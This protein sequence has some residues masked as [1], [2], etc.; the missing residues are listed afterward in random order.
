MDHTREGLP[1]YEHVVQLPDT[2]VSGI[3]GYSGKCEMMETSQTVGELDAPNQVLELP[4]NREFVELAADGP[5][6]A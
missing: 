6:R 3:R 1:L 4:T 5:G 2:Q